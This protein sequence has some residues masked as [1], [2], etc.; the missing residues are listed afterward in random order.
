[1]FIVIEGSDGSGKATQTKRTIERLQ[2]AGKEVETIDFPQYGQ[3]SAGL[4]E[5]YLEGKYGTAG[6][7]TP[8][9]GSLFYALDRYDASFTIRPW[10]EAG[11][12]VVA[13]RY[14]T[15]NA[16]HQG[17][18]I[19]DPEERRKFFQWLKDTEHGL[20]NEPVPDLIIYLNVEPEVT[21][22]LM[23]NRETTDIHE[24]DLEHLQ[25][26]HKVYQEIGE[27]FD[28][29][30]SIPCTENGQIKSIEA[31]NDLIWDHIQKLI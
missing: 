6:D 2:E 16:G 22:E 27:I 14:V 18:K 31:I 19:E 20:L 1:M 26:T 24:S 10:L 11:K 23:K 28:N 12:I 30:V 8:Y 5:N 3:K 29:V 9:Q 4:V 15:S 21:L 13:D 17:S 25:K 7:V